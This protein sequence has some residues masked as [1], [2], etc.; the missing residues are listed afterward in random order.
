MA[1]V[2]TRSPWPPRPI[3]PPESAVTVVLPV[4]PELAEAL[5]VGAAAMTPPEA[6][7]PQ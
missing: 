4:S 2:P 3:D 1:R 5:L 6:E 7:S